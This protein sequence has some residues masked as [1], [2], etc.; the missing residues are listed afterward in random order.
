LH[1]IK[2][3]KELWGMKWLRSTRDSAS[4]RKTAQAKFVVGHVTFLSCGWRVSPVALTVTATWL[5]LLRLEKRKSNAQRKAA[6]FRSPQR[7]RTHKWS[8]HVTDSAGGHVK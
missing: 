7:Q 6:E 2:R 4:E 1:T 8:R 5:R 3:G